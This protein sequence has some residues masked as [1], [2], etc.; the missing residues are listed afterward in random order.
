MANNRFYLACKQ[1]VL[2]DGIQDDFMFYIGKYFP[3]DGWYRHCTEV[4]EDKLNEWMEKHSHLENNT[5]FGYDDEGDPPFFL[6]YEAGNRYQDK[7]LSVLSKIGSGIT[8]PF[9]ET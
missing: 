4:L 1:C 8:L 9:K 3:S 5:L 2:D 7:I 6:Y